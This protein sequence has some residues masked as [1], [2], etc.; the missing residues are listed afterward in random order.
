MP[1]KAG[2]RTIP[3]GRAASAACVGALTTLV[4]A[5]IVPHA[6]YRAFHSAWTNGSVPG[7]TPQTPFGAISVRHR[8]FVDLYEV[9]PGAYRRACAQPSAPRPPHAVRVDGDPAIYARVDTALCGWPMRAMASEAWVPSSGPLE[10]RWN[11]HLTDRPEGP[12][13]IPLRPIAIG[14]AVDTVAFATAWFALLSLP[15]HR[16][17]WWREGWRLRTGRCP[18]CGHDLKWDLKAGCSECGWRKR[19]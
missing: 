11:W 5:C 18:E 1:R 3:W 10:F 2:E 19:G 14:F 15:V 12:V 8:P 6:W 4:V 16:P 9:S 7:V 17:G 13:L